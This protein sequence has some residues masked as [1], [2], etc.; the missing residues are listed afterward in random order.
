MSGLRLPPH[1]VGGLIR[2]K[3]TSETRAGSPSDRPEAR[4]DARRLRAINLMNVYIR[5]VETRK[6]CYKITVNV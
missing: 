2:P 6:R 1:H 4:E 3:N 5:S